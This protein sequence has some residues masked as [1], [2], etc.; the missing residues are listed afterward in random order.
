MITLWP[1]FNFVGQ[2]DSD[3]AVSPCSYRYSKYVLFAVNSFAD[4]GRFETDS[5]LSF[6]FD[7]APDP[8]VLSAK[9]LLYAVLRT[10]IAFSA[11][12]DP[13]K[14]LNKDPDSWIWLTAASKFQCKGF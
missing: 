6:Q 8:I 2:S 4:P 12:P 14:N 13:G 5:D 7:T 10:R 3:I 11:D 9:A 1:V